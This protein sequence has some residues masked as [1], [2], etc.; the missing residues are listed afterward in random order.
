VL[1]SCCHQTVGKLRNPASGVGKHSLRYGKAG[2]YSGTT[3]PSKRPGHGVL[4]FLDIWAQKSREQSLG[5]FG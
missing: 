2:A 1:I 4:R 5:P 3:G